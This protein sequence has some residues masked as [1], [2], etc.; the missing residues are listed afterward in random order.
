MPFGLAEPGGPERLDQ[1]PGHG[2]SHGSSAHANDVHVIVLDALPGREMVVD[3]TGADT[4]DFVGA[5]RRADAAAAD[6]DAAFHFLGGHRPGER[7]DEVRIVVAG[8]QRVLGR[9]VRPRVRP[10]S[11]IFLN[12]GTPRLPRPFADGRPKESFGF[13]QLDRQIQSSFAATALA[14]SKKIAVSQSAEPVNAVR[15]SPHLFSRLLIVCSR[16]LRNMCSV[17]PAV[18]S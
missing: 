11:G 16:L 2:R 9:I 6:R 13:I 8:A 15:N 10:N 3:Q 12:L 1:I 18:S 5:H 17:C 4:R 7:N 14:S